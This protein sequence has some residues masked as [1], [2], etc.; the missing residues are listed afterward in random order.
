MKGERKMNFSIKAVYDEYMEHEE[1]ETRRK[2]V[3]KIYHYA[4]NTRDEI[5]NLSISEFAENT[6]GHEIDEN[7]DYIVYRTYGGPTCWLNLSERLIFCTYNTEKVTLDIDQVDCE[8]MQEYFFTGEN[9]E[10][11]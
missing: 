7:G 11:I 2:I 3:D 4:L 6:C 9:Y 1:N 5:E 10:K 8:R